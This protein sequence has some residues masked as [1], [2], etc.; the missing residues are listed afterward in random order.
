[1]C[2]LSLSLPVSLYPH[3]K[4]FFKADLSVPEI[5][6]FP[7]LFT[8]TLLSDIIVTQSWSALP[9]C[10]MWPQLFFP[11]ILV[12]TFHMK[13]TKAVLLEG[14]ELLSCSGPGTGWFLLLSP[15]PFERKAKG[16]IKEQKEFCSQSIP[17]AINLL[18][19]GC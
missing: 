11:L 14:V 7:K 10:R 16:L 2:F 3:K 13:P 6:N 15:S 19:E 5:Q 17:A 9:E 12:C 4:N 18:G 8:F 1:M